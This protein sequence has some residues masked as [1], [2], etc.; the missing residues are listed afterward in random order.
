ME[1]CCGDNNCAIHAPN[2]NHHYH[3]SHNNHIGAF[4]DHDSGPGSTQA[5][6]RPSIHKYDYLTTKACT[7]AAPPRPIDHHNDR[8]AD[9][10]H[11]T[12]C[13][14]DHHASGDRRRANYQ[15]VTAGTGG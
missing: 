6:R 13:A 4:T 3:Y 8:S 14:F 15:P 1:S 10:N 5:S 12:T 2:A 9:D 7:S 11:C